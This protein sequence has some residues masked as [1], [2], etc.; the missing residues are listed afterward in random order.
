MHALSGAG[1]SGDEWTPAERS[2]RCTETVNSVA[3][4]RH[5]FE[6]LV[7]ASAGLATEEIRCRTLNHDSIATVPITT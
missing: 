2:S 7:E 1:D 3:Y 4:N 5:F 6:G